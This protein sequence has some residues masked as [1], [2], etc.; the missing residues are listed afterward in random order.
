VGKFWQT[1]SFWLTVG[2][3][4]AAVLTS[5]GLGHL[6]TTVRAAIDAGALVVSAAY[7]H[8]VGS[9]HVT[10]APTTAEAVGDV[11]TEAAGKLRG[12]K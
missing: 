5:A 8:G 4:A 7:V 11:L 9:K 10:T 12:G 2:S 1:E 3:A 6:A